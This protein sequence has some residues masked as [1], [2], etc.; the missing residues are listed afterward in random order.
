[1]GFSNVVVMIPFCRSAREADRVLDASAACTFNR[2][3]ETD[4]ILWAGRDGG[5]AAVKLNG[6]LVTLDPA[7]ALQ[8][9]AARFAAPG[10]AITVRP[11]GDDA[12]WRQNAELIFE[13]D[14]GLRVGYRGFSTCGAG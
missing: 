4:P 11:L 7:E 8:D 13:L 9:G 10:T 14:R 12:D 6:V 5:A 3:P 1:M 2:S